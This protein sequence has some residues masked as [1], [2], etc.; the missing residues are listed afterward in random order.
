MVLTLSSSC[1]NLYSLLQPVEVPLPSYPSIH[2]CTHHTVGG[3][4]LNFQTQY[5]K[6][7]LPPTQIN[8]IKI[9]LYKI[10]KQKKLMGIFKLVF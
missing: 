9:I 8:N 5:Q 10:T 4:P 6:G 7:W 3:S 2:R 1:C